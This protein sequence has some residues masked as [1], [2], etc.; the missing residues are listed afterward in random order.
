MKAK[1]QSPNINFVLVWKIK[2]RNHTNKNCKFMRK[3]TCTKFEF[4]VGVAFILFLDLLQSSFTPIADLI[5]SYCITHKIVFFIPNLHTCT[6]NNCI[7]SPLRFMV[8]VWAGS[9]PIPSWHMTKVPL[10]SAV[11]V[12][13]AVDVM[14]VPVLTSVTLNSNGGSGI[15]WPW[16]AGRRL[17]V[18]LRD[19]TVHRCAR[20]ATVQVNSIL[21]PG[22]GLS[23]LDCNWAFETEK[24]WHCS[25]LIS[26]KQSPCIQYQLS[27]RIA[28]EAKTS[29]TYMQWVCKSL[30]RPNKPE[31][32]TENKDGSRVF[33]PA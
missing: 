5:S 24:E 22:H 17:S 20:E 8:L 32:F 23:T 18:I 6:H 26:I 2:Y 9:D 30:H 10:R 13:V 33:S 31:L 21:S 3:Y 27:L 12:T 7:Y 15:T 16:L 11:A 14:D 29:A 25:Y 28:H 19:G 1:I 4:L